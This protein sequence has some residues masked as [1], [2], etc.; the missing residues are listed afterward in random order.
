[1]AELR[2]LKEP[3][4]QAAK[5]GLPTKSG[6]NCFTPELLAKLKA[7]HAQLRAATEAK[8]AALK[9]TFT[10]KGSVVGTGRGLGEKAS[11]WNGL[12]R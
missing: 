1:M 11:S 7:K 10:A 4:T 6:S 5:D 8:L 2:R 12:E 3:R 9:A